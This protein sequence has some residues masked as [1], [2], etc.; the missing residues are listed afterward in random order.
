MFECTDVPTRRQPRY[1]VVE[2][3]TAASNAVGDITSRYVSA[4]VGCEGTDRSITQHE[5]SRYHFGGGLQ[6]DCSE[7]R[8]LRRRARPFTLRLMPWVSWTGA[9]QR[10]AAAAASIDVTV[11]ARPTLSTTKRTRRRPNL[12]QHCWFF[13]W[14]TIVMPVHSRQM[15]S[16]DI[17]SSRAAQKIAVIPY[18]PILF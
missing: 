15:S 14:K 16:D 3:A 7:M 10:I 6:S 8:R 11:S 9:S 5:P 1:P 2:M 17:A 18:P 4:A 12:V 13:T